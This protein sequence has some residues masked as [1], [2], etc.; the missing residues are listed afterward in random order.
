MEFIKQIEDDYDDE[1]NCQIAP[2]ILNKN[3]TSE[4]I[5]QWCKDRTKKYPTKAKAEKGELVRQF[6]MRQ[7][8][9]KS[10][11]EIQNK[12]KA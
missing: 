4:S 9:K 5:Q 12:N 2:A 10:R 7:F 8:F 1:R 3:W 11:D 6:R